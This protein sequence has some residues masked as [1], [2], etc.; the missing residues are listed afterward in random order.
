MQYN[1]ILCFRN[2]T[3]FEWFLLKIDV[4]FFLM[5]NTLLKICH[6]IFLNKNFQIFDAN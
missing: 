6:S 3:I 5:W 2:L 4:H 1:I